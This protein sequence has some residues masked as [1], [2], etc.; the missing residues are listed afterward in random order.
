MSTLSARTS[1]ARTADA[2]R[3]RNPE[4]ADFVGQLKVQQVKSTNHCKQNQRDTIRTLGLKRIGDVVIKENRPEIRGMVHTVRH[5]VSVEEIGSVAPPA[6]DSTGGIAMSELRSDLVSSREGVR[7]FAKGE[8]LEW[9]KSDDG[10]SLIWSSRLPLIDLLDVI[11]RAIGPADLEHRGLVDVDDSPGEPTTARAARELA[12]SDPDSVTFL[13]LEFR[14]GIAVVWTPR[15][16]SVELDARSTFAE[17][18]VYFTPQSV[19]VAAEM[20]SETA[21]A[22]LAPLAATI[23][24]SVAA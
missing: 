24:Q 18:S 2:W 14:D 6:A 9:H 22:Y 17:A 1:K 12:L 19:D 21:T 20:M 3:Y 5:L 16:G 15:P 23:A 8:F 11:S 13:R 4:V 10:R 7:V